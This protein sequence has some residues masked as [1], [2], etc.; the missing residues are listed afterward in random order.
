MLR[1]IVLLEGEPPSQSQIFG[2]LKLSR[3]SLNLAPSINLF[4]TMLHCGD[5]VLG[6]MRGVGFATD[7]VFLDGQ[8]AQF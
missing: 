7:S 1:V 2:R 4:T 3:I 5:C 8:K 6:L